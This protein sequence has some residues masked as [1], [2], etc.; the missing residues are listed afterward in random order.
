VSLAD[1]LNADGPRRSNR[2]CVSCAYYLG[3]S[4]P[5]RVAF[6]V[7]VQ[8]GHSTVQLWEACITDTPPL[9]V[10]VTALRNHMRHHVPQ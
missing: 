1:R 6:D 9:T 5:D 8:E 4:K 3:L 2:G 7:W 10:S